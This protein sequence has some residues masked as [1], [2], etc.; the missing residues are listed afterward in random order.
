[1]DEGLDAGFVKVAEIGGCL[2]RFLAVHECLWIDEAESVNDHFA[3]YGLDG[4]DDDGDGAGCELLEGLLCVDVDAGKPA[5]ET[6][7]RV[8]P[9][10]YCFRSA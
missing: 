4:I 9:A 7:V 6:R 3:F 8:V 5:A 10:Y 1:M 2:A